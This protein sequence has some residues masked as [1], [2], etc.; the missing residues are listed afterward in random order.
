MPKKKNRAV[1][2]AAIV[3]AVRALG[4]Y[5]KDAQ[6]PDY[7]A[8]LFLSRKLK[9]MVW[10]LR[11]VQKIG[12]GYLERSA[13]GFYWYFQVRT[14]HIDAI[15]EKAINTGIEQLVIL[16][17]GYDSRPYRFKEKLNGIRVFEVDF[18]GTLSTKKQKLIKLYGSLPK[19][20]RY[21]PID[22]NSQSIK[23]VLLENGYE[24][25]RKTF[26][27]WE[28]VSYYLT[29]N[30]FDAVLEFAAKN[31]PPTSSIAFDYAIR[32]FIEGDYSTY[33]AKKLADTWEKMGEPGLSGI[34]D[35]ATDRFLK[36]KGIEYHF[37]FWFR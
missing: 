19:Y 12:K 14:K 24:A 33:G 23:D 8:I 31:S 37:R 29:N 32:S 6:N 11:I 13:P 10:L 5:D 22:F 21:I 16:G 25:D 15:L 4:F 20:V 30:S 7:M 34:E 28:G 26:F 35:G 3:T 27:I 36:R 1:R 2:S 18:P 17:A 9:I